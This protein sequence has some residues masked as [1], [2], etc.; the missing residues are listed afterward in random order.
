MEFSWGSVLIVGIPG[1]LA[2]C[3]V[4]Y[5]EYRKRQN[6]KEDA[7]RTQ[8]SKREP[9]W[10]ELTEGYSKLHGQVDTLNGKL[11][12]LSGDFDT[13]KRSTNRKIDAFSNVLRDASEQWPETHP[14]PVFS[15]DD[16]E[17]LEDTEVPVRWRGR[18]RPVQ[19]LA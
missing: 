11:S 19:G 14:G 12:S 9:T 16:L 13:Y 8:A 18:V 1:F 2:L 15:P 7:N 10:N 3:G 5:G 4:I 17:A 6:A